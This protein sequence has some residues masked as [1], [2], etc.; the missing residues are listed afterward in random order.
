MTDVWKMHKPNAY[1]AIFQYTSAYIFIQFSVHKYLPNPS[2]HAFLPRDLIRS[3]IRSRKNM[4][5]IR[6]STS[7]LL[8]YKYQQNVGRYRRH[9][10]PVRRHT[11]L[12]ST[13]YWSFVV[14]M[15]MNFKVT[16]VNK[17]LIKS[18]LIGRRTS[19]STR[20]QDVTCVARDRIVIAQNTTLGLTSHVV[21]DKTAS[22]RCYY[23]LYES[24]FVCPEMF[25]IIAP[26]LD[27]VPAWFQNKYF[28]GNIKKTK[29][30][31]D[32]CTPVWL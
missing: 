22:T 3:L 6:A 23:A 5:I 32:L 2:H 1:L 29:K 19:W 24:R 8:K 10:P 26:A 20:R 7:L 31:L 27:N 30:K 11:S 14:P 4:E 16:L 13:S 15:Q 9:S 21:C 17:I 18:N 12:E 25:N 28:Y